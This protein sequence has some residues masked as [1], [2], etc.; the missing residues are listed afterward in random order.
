MITAKYIRLLLLGFGFALGCYIAFRFIGCNQHPAPAASIT[1]KPPEA[2]RRELTNVTTP[3]QARVDSLNT[4]NLMLTGQLKRTEQ[5]L[6]VAK[7]QT[8]NLQQEIYTLLNRQPMDSPVTDT[9]GT[10]RDCDSLQ[11]NVRTLLAADAQKDSL[12]EAVAAQLRLQ[13]TNRDSVIQAEQSI[14]RLF[15]TTLDTALLQQQV[16]QGQVDFYQ[17]QYRRQKNKN[18]IAGAGLCIAAGILIHSL[19]QR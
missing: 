9:I 3:L 18:K 11:R 1:V 12:H 8:N 13:V 10:L 7:G 2:I 19:M 16:L 6:A 14:S 5:A 4:H 15:R 17:K